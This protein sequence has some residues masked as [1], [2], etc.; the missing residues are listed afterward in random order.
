M[1]RAENEIQRAIVQY[2]AA[3]APDVLVYAVPNASRRSRDGRAG[4][5]VPGLTKGV[6]DLAL[7]L[8]KGQAAF[9]EVKSGVG[10]LSPDQRAFRMRL[11]SMGV[12]CA[13]CRSVDDVRLALRQW[14]VATR[15]AERGEA[16]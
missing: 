8:P 3:V 9:I 12:P 15:E 13:T 11:I 2:L 1:I 4:N 6:P 5:A 16:A 14:S 10:K 7:V